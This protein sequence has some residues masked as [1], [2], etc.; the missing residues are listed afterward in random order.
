[1]ALQYR[2]RKIFILCVENTLYFV[3][4]HKQKIHNFF[5]WKKLIIFHEFQKKQSKNW[6]KTSRVRDTHSSRGNRIFMDCREKN[7]LFAQKH[8][9]TPSSE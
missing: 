4:R 2:C 5:M 7:Y 1:M 8:R 6:Q 3:W 9:D